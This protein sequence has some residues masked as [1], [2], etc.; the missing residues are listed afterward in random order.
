MSSRKEPGMME[1]NLEPRGI[2]KFANHL[3]KT[4]TQTWGTQT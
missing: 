3:F 4:R 2:M 1:S